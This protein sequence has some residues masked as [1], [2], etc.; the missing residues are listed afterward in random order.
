MVAPEGVVRLIVE[1]SL[2]F[3]YALRRFSSHRRNLSSEAWEQFPGVAPN[4]YKPTVLTEN[5]LPVPTTFPSHL[6]PIPCP[7]SAY[8][9]PVSDPSFDD[10]LISGPVEQFA[11]LAAQ[12]ET[13]LVSLPA[14]DGSGGR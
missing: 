1:I 7:P 3:S 12:D 10:P 8:P 14:D 13:C 11:T 5:S 9:P 2:R 6:S 4:P